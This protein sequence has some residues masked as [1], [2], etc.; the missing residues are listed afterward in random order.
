MKGYEHVLSFAIEHPWNLT[1]PMLQIVAEI[2]ARRVAGETVSRD[3]ILAAVA[4]RKDLPQAKRGNVAVIPIHGVLAPRMNVFSEMSGGTSYQEIGAQ[5]REAVQSP[6]I[7]SIVLDIDSPG[8]SVA[9]NAELASEIMKARTS[10]PVIAQA[11]YTMASAAYHLAAAAT[12]IVAS[13][14]ARIGSIGTFTI[15]DDLSAA[16]EQHGV[17]RTFI[18]AGDGKVDGNETGPLSDRARS[19]LQKSVDEAYSQFVANVVRGRG[20]GVTAR[21]VQEDWKAHVYGAAEAKDLGMIDRV[22][23]LDE[24]L[25]RVLDGP[26]ASTTP[27]SRDT[28][29]TAREDGAAQDRI[30]DPDLERLAFEVQ[31]SAIETGL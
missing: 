19:R 27:A 17:K 14:S 15:H 7:A 21:K 8:G 12:E 13:P 24:T 29:Q 1:R 11:Q 22:A 9:G 23:T 20:A 18:S 10:K 4:K 16:L 30:V 26:T 31:L 28:A 25:A 2:L 6:A 5:L 3:E